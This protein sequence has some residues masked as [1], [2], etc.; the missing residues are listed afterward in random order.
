MNNL[1]NEKASIQAHL[2]DIN[3]EIIRKAITFI[4]N[5]KLLCLHF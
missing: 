3:A 1:S 5:G 2:K 4:N